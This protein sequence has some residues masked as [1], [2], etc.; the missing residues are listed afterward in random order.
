MFHVK[1]F[2]LILLATL[3]LGAS[4]AFSQVLYDAP[5]K[6]A[7][8]PSATPGVDRYMVTMRRDKTNEEWNY[9]TGNL[10]L[11]L[12]RPKSGVYTLEVRAGKVGDDQVL[13]WSDPCSSLSLTCAKLK[14]GTP[15][16]WKIRWKVSA[17]TGPLV[18]Y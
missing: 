2:L 8:D 13:R 4:V 9:G 6:V 16:I 12:P 17:P 11:Q 7:W 5:A 14:D 1:Q 15:G 3:I 18:V 10:Y